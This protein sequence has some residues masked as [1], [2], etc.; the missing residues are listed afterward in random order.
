M[1]PNQKNYMIMN[2]CNN[3]YNRAKSGNIDESEQNE[4]IKDLQRFADGS[5][6]DEDEENE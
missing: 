5:I 3:I 6:D 4:I 2:L 1:T